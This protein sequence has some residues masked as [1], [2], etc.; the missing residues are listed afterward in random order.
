MAASTP[1]NSEQSSDTI[2]QNLE[3]QVDEIELLQSMYAG[4]GEFTIEDP[5]VFD[6]MKS[7]IY[8]HDNSTTV[9]PCSLRCTIRLKI[10]WQE[11]DDEDGEVEEWSFSISV[12]CRLPNTY[13]TPDT[14]EVYIHSDSLSRTA[15]DRFNAAISA[16]ISDECSTNDVC[17]LS[18]IEFIRD[19]APTYYAP[20]VAP[21]GRDARVSKE[22]K[23]T[24][25]RMWL[26]MHHIYSKTKR[27][28]IL[29]L[30]NELE[31]T[32]FCLPGKPGVVCVEGTSR[33]TEDFFGALRRWNWKS[34]TCRK[35]ETLPDANVS[36]CKKIAGFCELALDTHGPRANH[37][38][39]GQFREYLQNHQLE[40]MF[41]E[42]FGIE[43]MSGT[44]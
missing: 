5:L 16:Y 13:P 19:S 25:C 41:K 21:A 3:Q 27:R 28:N 12:H 33:Q 20:V 9:H 2:K 22:D 4:D 10:E 14:P 39:M 17:L 38:N 23:R 42:L 30:A 6:T 24:F 29:S 32:G 8:N 7:Y 26:Y 34:I 35:R 1:S 15:H 36:K 40:Y 11:E 31:L 37:M 44:S 43:G 18:V